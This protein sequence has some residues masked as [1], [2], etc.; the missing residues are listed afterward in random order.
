MGDETCVDI[1][2]A[3]IYPE[4]IL[5]EDIELANLKAPRVG[6][7]PS[8]KAPG[9]S[10]GIFNEVLTRLRTFAMRHGFKAIRAH[11]VDQQLANIFQ[12]RGFQPDRL[13]RELFELSHDTG[14]QIP[15]VLP[16]EMAANANE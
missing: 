8:Q 10:H 1:H 16:L 2:L 13:D 6:L 3:G 15:L 5:I 14:I 12:R 7:M 9:L 4:S 11:A